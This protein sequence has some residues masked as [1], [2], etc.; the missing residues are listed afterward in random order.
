MG[1]IAAGLRL[2][3]RR[4]RLVG[5]GRRVPRFGMPKVGM[6]HRL[7]HATRRPAGH[8][9]GQRVLDVARSP[10][11]GLEST[12]RP[13]GD[14]GRTQQSRMSPFPSLPRSKGRR[15]YTSETEAEVE[16]GLSETLCDYT[17]L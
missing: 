9:I 12:L 8:A 3:K 1:P 13:R 17:K 10:A 2:V 7:N 14:S 11:I 4:L 16:I 6:A 15:V 5:D